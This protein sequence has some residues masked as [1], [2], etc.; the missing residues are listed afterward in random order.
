MVDWE[1]KLFVTPII[2]MFSSMWKTHLPF[3]GKADTLE[4]DNI[5]TQKIDDKTNIFAQRF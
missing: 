4:T 5:I 1:N 2:G 3:S